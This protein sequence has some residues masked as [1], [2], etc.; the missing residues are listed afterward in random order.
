MCPLDLADTLPPL[1]FGGSRLGAFSAPEIASMFDTPRLARNFP[2]RPLESERLAQ[3]QWLVVE[4]EIAVDARPEARAVPGL[5]MDMGR[6][7]GE[8]EPHLGRF[9]P[10]V[11]AALFFLLLAPWEEW[12]T[13][14]EA[15][16]R[17]FRVPGI[18]TVDEDLFVRPDPPPSPDSL[19]L[20]PWI[21]Q[22]R[23]GK[24]IELER[25]SRLPLDNAMEAGL[26]RF[27]DAAWKKLG[28][29]EATSL[30]ET[31]TVHFLVRAFLA[32]GM[33]EVMAHMTS[34]EAALGL[35]MDHKARLRPK[36]DRHKGV[37]ASDRV[38][39]RIAALLDDPPSVGAYKELFELRSNFVHGRARMQKVSTPL[40]VRARHLARRVARALVDVAVSQ[41]TRPRNDVMA[42]LLDTGVQFL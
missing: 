17:G 36:P 38:A 21:V 8:I 18:Y 28:A 15:D 25:P 3:F 11:E 5:F 42:D 37:S 33:D 24:E 27:T 16:W 22:D 29:A 26:A 32:D 2:T 9:P 4:E 41:P 10:V 7:L 19:T 12:S 13:M 1:T 30:F 20:E 14:P 23:W 6:D 31:P 35:E 39:A 34:I 40:Q